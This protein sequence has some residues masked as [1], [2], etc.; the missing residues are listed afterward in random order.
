MDF[1]SFQLG[2]IVG[3]VYLMRI[4][5]EMLDKIIRL[6]GTALEAIDREPLIPE[7]VYMKIRQPV[8][9]IR[10]ALDLAKAESKGE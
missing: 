1:N 10:I 8:K 4:S 6:T 3:Q 9:D 7:R 5:R 2:F